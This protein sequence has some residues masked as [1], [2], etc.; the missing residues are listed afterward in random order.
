MYHTTQIRE[1][2]LHYMLCAGIT[3]RLFVCMQYYGHKIGF[4]D[5]CDKLTTLKLVSTV[6]V[7]KILHILQ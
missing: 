3:P 2:S 6:S 4:F 5:S 7:F 1:L